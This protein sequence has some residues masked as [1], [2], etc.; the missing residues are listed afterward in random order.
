MYR[1]LQ[2]VISPGRKTSHFRASTYPRT[3][4]L[5]HSINEP[6]EALLKSGPQ[7]VEAKAG[8]VTDGETIYRGRARQHRQ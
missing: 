8:A 1:R 3:I 6:Y 5:T 7:I 4:A 2:S